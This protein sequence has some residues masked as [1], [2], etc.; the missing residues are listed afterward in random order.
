[1]KARLVPLD[2]P[3]LD[4]PLG[5]GLWTVPRIQGVPESTTVL[6]R[7]APGV[8]KTVFG[9][10]LA[11]SVARALGGD[12]AY[13]CI[14]LLP[15]EFQAQHAGLRREDVDEEVVVP[16][17]KKGKPSKKEKGC[18][19]FAGLL[20]LG[21]AGDE[22]SRLGPAVD[23]LLHQVEQVGGRPRV[24]V[25]DSLSD[26]YNLGGS[27]PRQLADA[28]CKLAAE[29]GLV[30]IL[31]EEAADIRPSV[32]S[33]AVDVVL[34]LKLS[35]EDSVA[36]MTVTLDRW[37][38]V[39]K[40]RFG[41]SDAGPHRFSMSPGAGVSVTPRPL[42]Y[43]VNWAPTIL[44]NGWKSP[45]PAAQGW[46]VGDPVTTLPWPKFRECVTAVYGSYAH[47]VWRVAYQ[48][49]QHLRNVRPENTE[50]LLIDFGLQRQSQR[51][52]KYAQASVTEISA[53][54]PYLAGGELI[55]AVRDTLKEVR[56][57]KVVV[58]KAIIG[59]LRAIR[60]F[61]NSE[62]IRMAVGIIVAMLRQVRIPVVLFETA[63]PRAGEA[64]PE[65][66]DFADVVVSIPVTSNLPISA[67]MTDTRT[68]LRHSWSEHL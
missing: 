63:T 42:A 17:F 15:V 31:L 5:G 52:L 47:V 27:A 37:L 1:M 39:I 2:I 4:L 61:R 7:G 11:G 40:N 24:L 10:Q 21:A 32:W 29:R 26:G 6:V 12:V 35:E 48:L 50:L 9:S 44:W 64:E 51:E 36:G 34:E 38:T 28:L 8:G 68:G 13:G 67:T 16:P 19:F 55:E 66:V 56:D 41:P 57:S 49:G 54:N 65:C 59:D 22:Q 20:D 60:S 23:A 3:G 25:I 45:E 43:L 46:A 53:G 62:E 58:E 14:E 30:L 33:F 18:R